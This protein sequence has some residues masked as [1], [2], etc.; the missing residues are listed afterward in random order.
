MSVLG[1]IDFIWLMMNVPCTVLAGVVILADY[2]PEQPRKAITWDGYKNDPIGSTATPLPRL[3]A[4]LECYPNNYDTAPAISIAFAE[5][6]GIG[7]KLTNRSRTNYNYELE[8]NRCKLNSPVGVGLVAQASK[9]ATV[10]QAENDAMALVRRLFVNRSTV[11]LDEAL[12]YASVY[13]D[14]VQYYGTT[15]PLADVISDKQK[16]FSEWP[17]RTYRIN[18]DM[19]NC[20]EVSNQ[21]GQCTI[22]G[23]VDFDVSNATN[24]VLAT[25]TFEYA[26]KPDQWGKLK[27]TA[28]DG[29]LLMRR[30]TNR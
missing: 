6:G 20:V 5:G 22:S 23:T 29:K 7:S 12:L 27:I 17:R 3:N 30:V 26:L 8:S 21:I 10:V 11:V 25:A 14:T 28:E 4:K 18:S 24:R 15:T 2:K 9:S 13:A 16:F 1:I 19:T